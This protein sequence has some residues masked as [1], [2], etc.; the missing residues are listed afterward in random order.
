M[1]FFPE[2]DIASKHDIAE[3]RDPLHHLYKLSKMTQRISWN[4][5]GAIFFPLHETLKQFNKELICHYDKLVEHIST[6]EDSSHEFSRFIYGTVHLKNPPM[7]T[8]QLLMELRIL[9]EHYHATVFTLN[10][11]LLRLRDPAI[12]RMLRA[13]SANLIRVKNAINESI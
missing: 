8:S 7:N 2:V 12:R 3:L 11:T 5:R 1:N 13:I 4:L 9:S 10:H 6:S